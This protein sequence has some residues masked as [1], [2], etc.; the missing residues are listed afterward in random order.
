MSIKT[1]LVCLILITASLLV[2]IHL[3]STDNEFA[4][5]NINWNGTSIFFS[6]LEKHTVHEIYSTDN[7]AGWNNTTLL[8]IAPKG[9]YSSAQMSALRNYIHRGNTLFL[10]D[11]FGSGNTILKEVGS[12]IT[13]LPEH[14]LSLDQAYRDP[15]LI[16]TSPVREHPLTKGVESIVLDHSGVIQGGEIL[17]QSSLMSWV[18]KN[19]DRRVSSGEPFGRYATLT[20]EKAGMGEIIVLSDPSIFINSMRGLDHTWK[21]EIFFR[22]ILNYREIILLDQMLSRTADVSLPGRAVIMI[23]TNQDTKIIIITIVLLCIGIIMRRRII[24]CPSELFQPDMNTGE[25]TD[26]TLLPQNQ[27]RRE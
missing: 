11:D 9:E 16:V 2:F 1:Y 27:R 12:S 19:Q 22:N 3:G 7:L 8:L 24:H 6:D 10:V 25:K 13:I 21:N 23:R 14:L 17:M 20:W 4:R 18:D 5:N 15:A 26:T